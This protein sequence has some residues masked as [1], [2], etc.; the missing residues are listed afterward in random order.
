[1]RARIGRDGNVIA[2]SLDHAVPTSA[3]AALGEVTLAAVKSWTFEP[4]RSNGAA[5]EAEVMVPVEFADH[6]ATRA[7]AVAAQP[8]ALDT[9][10][11]RT[12]AM[13]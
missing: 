13:Q 4:A 7:D 2:A 6:A 11:I 10:T 3:A 9:I 8:T 1:V 12:D 5:V